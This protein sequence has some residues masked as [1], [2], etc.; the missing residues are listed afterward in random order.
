ML[1]VVGTRSQ[2][3]PPMAMRQGVDV[4][5]RHFPPGGF[6]QRRA[7]L[8]G[9]KQVAG[10]GPAQLPGEEGA[11]PIQRE[12]PPAPAAAPVAFQPLRA[13]RV[14]LTQPLPH[15]LRRD[16]QQFGELKAVYR[17]V[18]RTAATLKRELATHTLFD[19]RPFQDLVL[20]ASIGAKQRIASLRDE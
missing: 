2:L 14:V 19:T 17:D 16:G 15:S 20:A 12:E 13:E 4:V 6:R 18:T 8:L 11:L 9:G 7:K 5:E 10:S 3:P 1:G